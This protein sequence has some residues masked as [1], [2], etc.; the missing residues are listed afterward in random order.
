MPEAANKAIQDLRD[1]GS[2]PYRQGAKS[3]PALSLIK[4][5]GVIDSVE[6]FESSDAPF[7][8]VINSYTNQIPGHV[9][10]DVIGHH[11]F[12]SL[13]E[14]GLNVFYANVGG[15]I[16]DGI[17]MGQEF[18]MN[19][20]LPSRE[21]IADQVEMILGAHPTDGVVT[22]ANCDKIV[23]GMIMGMARV[24]IPGLYISGGPMLASRENK[25][26]ISV[27]QGV[28]AHSKGKMSLEELKG[29]A[30]EACPGCGSCA[31][32]FTANSM[33]CAAEALGIAAPGNGTIPAGTWAEDGSYV[34]NPDRIEFSRKTAKHIK[35]LMETRTRPSN[36][37]TRKSVDNA[38]IAENAFGGS[39]NLALHMLAIANELGFDDYGLDR[40]D[41]LS[42]RTPNICK[43]SPSREEVHLQHLDEKGGISTIL[44]ELHGERLIYAGELT[45]TG[46]TIA[47]NIA[48]APAPDGDVIRTVKNPFSSTGGLAVLYGNLAPKGSIVK[49]AGVSDDMMKY[50]GEAIVFDSQKTA[51]DA[52]LAE[53]V[54]DGHVIVICYE[55][56]KGGPGMQEMLGPTSAVTGRGL[57]VGLVTDG[58]FSGGTKGPC[59]GHAAPEAALRGPI[60]AVR[61]GDRIRY[62]IPNKSIELLVDEDEIQRRLSELPP[63]EP[64]VKGGCLARYAYLVKG[65][66]TGAV[67]RNPFEE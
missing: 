61:N 34:I 51:Y 52:I 39:T 60:A 38:V 36:I 58:R 14:E 54:E 46:K 9:H 21:V 17:P 41:E 56:P 59:I 64:K 8:T 31:G 53:E 50:E 42:N 15:C 47:E 43:V 10:L 67:L 7:V 66:E 16:C 28:G 23:P 40:I 63:F 32:M 2:A 57:K 65:A 24:D 26:L 27:F 3:M 35:H 13:K 6:H 33:N 11:V 49:A 20:S 12:E 19:Y 25:D 48:D 30:E 29:L 55:G 62:D 4:A 22:I 44:K 45:I 18:N 1:L 37:M 5:S